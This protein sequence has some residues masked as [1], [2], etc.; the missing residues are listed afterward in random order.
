VNVGGDIT[1]GDADLYVV[2][3]DFTPAIGEAFYIIDNEGSDAISGQFT[4]AQEGSLITAGDITYMIT[5]DA[6]ADANGGLGSLTG[7]ND[8]AL[9]AVAVPEPAGGFGL[10]AAVMLIV[11]RSRRKN[12][13]ELPSH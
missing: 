6:D 10:V 5:Y 11:R 2:E 7:G 9:V 12:S 4:N 8:V 1:I 3:G 13:V